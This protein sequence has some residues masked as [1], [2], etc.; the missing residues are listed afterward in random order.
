MITFSYLDKSEKN[1]WLPRLFDLLYENMRAIAPTEL[2]YEQE[3]AAFLA[4][5]SPAL[6]R[7]QRQILLCFAEGELAG[8]IQYYVRG[9]LLMVEEVQLRREYQRTTF[10]L[11]MCRYLIRDLPEDLR[12]IE[13]Y[14]DP[15]N[16]HSLA[17]MEK[18][19][20]VPVPEENPAF[21]HLRGPADAV[22]K[23]FCGRV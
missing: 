9:E 10:F 17:L 19:G 5:V 15:R 14:A 21:V 1:I 7:P 13:A 12:Q 23:R 3:K 20:M 22:R 16:R 4:N 2:P 11:Q 6:D 8:Y 18:L